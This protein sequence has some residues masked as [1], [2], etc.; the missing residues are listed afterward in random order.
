[1]ENLDKRAVD[2]MQEDKR[3][4]YME[5]TLKHLPDCGEK[6][7][8]VDIELLLSQVPPRSGNKEP[9]ENVE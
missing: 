5:E 4:Q 7:E 8:F 3:K 1:M 2:R 9:Q 6:C